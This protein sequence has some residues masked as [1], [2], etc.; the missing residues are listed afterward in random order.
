MS[1]DQLSATS[2]EASDWCS[3]DLHGSVYL[4]P[5][6]SGMIVVRFRVNKPGTDGFVVGIADEQ[7]KTSCVGTSRQLGCIP[8]SWGWAAYNGTKSAIM[9]HGNWQAF[10]EKW[11][12]KG[13]EV[14]LTLDCDNGVLSVSVGSG[15]SLEAFNHPPWAGTPLYL[16]WHLRSSSITLLGVSL[17]R[18]RFESFRF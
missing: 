4:D 13:A 17:Q 18:P 16:G 14:E 11:N 9:E 1:E 3:F 12:R 10:T 2:A 6:D 8:N 5:V 7:G 15:V